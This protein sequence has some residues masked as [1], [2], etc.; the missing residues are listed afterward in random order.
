[1]RLIPYHNG[2]PYGGDLM[3]RFPVER[4]LTADQARARYR[5]CPHPV[6]KT[7]WHAPRLWLRTAHAARPRWRTLSACRSSPPATPCAGGT[8]SAPTG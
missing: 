4:H 5:A 7:R 3:R 1:M 2:V 8:A 6:E